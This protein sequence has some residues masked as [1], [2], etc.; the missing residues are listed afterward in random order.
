MNWCSAKEIASMSRA[1][2]I[3]GYPT[4]RDGVRRRCV[5]DGISSRLS[6]KRLYFSLPEILQKLDP[7]PIAKKKA[8]VA[9][10]NV[11][12][13]LAIKQ[14]AQKEKDKKSRFKSDLLHA[15]LSRIAEA[16]TKKRTQTAQDFV[17][18]YNN[19]I[20]Y[21]GIY[22][23]LGAVSFQTLERWKVRKRKEG[24]T[25]LI[26][27]R[28]GSN[29]K[30][31]L[32]PNQE[33]IL[34]AA[35]RHPHGLLKAEMIRLF[36]G[37]LEKAGLPFCPMSDSW[38]LRWIDRWIN[39]H[40]DQY[41]QAVKGHRAVIN[42]CAPHLRRDWN[43]I[44][45][46]EC[47]VADGHVWNGEIDHPR[48][49][50]ACRPVILEFY[51]MRSNMPLGIE[52]MPSENIRSIAAA[53][54]RA[55]IRL[56]KYPKYVYIDNG[57]AFR[58][59][60]FKGCPDFEQAGI[61]PFYDRFCTEL[62]IAKVRNARAKPVERHFRVLSELERLSPTYVGTC[63]SNKPAR[64]IQGEV[65]HQRFWEKIT[66]GV[67]PTIDELYFAV[68]HW[69][70]QEYS[71]RKQYGSHLEG[72]RPIDVLNSGLGTGVDIEKLNELMLYED[73]KQ[74]TQNGIKLRIN[75]QNEF[76]YNEIFYGKRGKVRVRYDR[77]AIV[78]KSID[79][80]EF[81]FEGVWHKAH[82]RLKTHPLAFY[83][84]TPD[85]K[86]EVENQIKQT[87]SLVKQTEKDFRQFV[88]DDAKKY[89]ALPAPAPVPKKEAVKTPAIDIESVLQE[90]AEMT[91]VATK[92]ATRPIFL[93]AVERY[94][95]LN[96]NPESVTHEDAVFMEGFTRGLYSIN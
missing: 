3:K 54:R 6:G 36:R 26:D 10:G 34:V 53:F 2:K 33:A 43:L 30:Y 94:D 76:F 72:A 18:E 29:A 38:I 28:G 85:Q 84:G 60:F 42:L 22:Q 93:S 1:G 88:E 55:V 75:G 37:N 46:G 51:D 86:T 13:Q 56:G 50:K 81:L 63:I 44:E 7:H 39:S 92:P 23:V 5:N 52:V 4:T 90:V 15:Y 79:W 64:L 19:G 8:G 25:A 74:I 47:L 11:N 67:R 89:M 58:A 24:E 78:S 41:V 12:K 77:Y 70:E 27:E 83:E 66:G 14:Q 9:E 45:V 48:T 65:L 57:K 87:N 21:K 82:I 40:Y 61:R 69:I 68:V 16:P 96:A 80:V 35:I 73:D 95:W 62:I 31:Q 32:T 91:T 17:Y 20:I 59:K 49:G 71:Y